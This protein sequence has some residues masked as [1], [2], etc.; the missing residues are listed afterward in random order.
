MTN[1]SRRARYCVPIAR[2][3]AR[4]SVPYAVLVAIAMWT[5]NALADS[6]ITVSATGEAKAKPTSVEITATVNAE[7]ELTADAVVKFND[8]KKKS[9]I[10]L[11][12]LKLAGLKIEPGGSSVS[13]AVDEQSQMRMMNGMGGQAGAPKTRMTEQLKLTVGNIGSMK[14][15]DVMD[16]IMKVIDTGRDA[17][18]SVG[19]KTPQNYYQAQIMAQNGSGYSMA[20]FRADDA[21]SARD[22]AYQLAM[23]EA[24][25]KAKKLADLAGVKLGAVV[26]VQESAAA[27]GSGNDTARMIA[28]MNGMVTPEGPSGVNGPTFTDIPVR[29]S[30][31]V[32]FA[33]DK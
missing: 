29:V 23:T 32:Q 25:A 6:G 17:G 13:V 31:T 4:N 2:P 7:A 10:A 8:A 19:P 15:T 12:A 20:T 30:V 24:K 21:S 16:T 11:E 27:A 33:I 22:Q 5:S 18:L 28:M 9:V 14:P 26:S 3:T 1:P